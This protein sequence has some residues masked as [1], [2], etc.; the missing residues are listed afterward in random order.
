MLTADSMPDSPEISNTI[1][2]DF[3]PAAIGGIFGY[4]PV[5]NLEYSFRA[6][7]KL[8]GQASFVFAYN[9]DIP[10][11]KTGI[12]IFVLAA[13]AFNQ[14]LSSWCLVRTKYAADMF[15]DAVPDRQNL[16]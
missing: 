12:G 4:F 9:A 3:A 8:F 14:E 7:K 5:G 15:I 1:R 16:H 6:D 2:F 10:G 11:F 13:A